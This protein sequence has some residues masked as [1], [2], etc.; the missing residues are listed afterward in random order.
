MENQSK[1]P[2]AEQQYEKALKASP[3]DLNALVGLARLHDRQGQ[4]VKAVQFYERAVKSHGKDALVYNDLGLYYARQKQL[5]KSIQYLAKAV[6]LQPDNARYRNNLATVLVESGR[7]GEAL[8]QLSRANS[9]AV[10]HY[11]VGF[12][13]HKRG[14][15]NEAVQHLQQ[16]IA[17]DPDLTPAREMLA[18]WSMGPDSGMVQQADPR[19]ADRP[20]YN[21]GN[22]YRT[23]V[24]SMPVSIEMPAADPEAPAGQYRISDEGNAN[25]AQAT[26]SDGPALRLPPLEE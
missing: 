14:Q 8:A 4:S 1:F 21:A 3:N 9:E 22:S 17:L 7:T 26:I 13:L 12:L 10:A 18:Q 5:D 24:P 16:A 15:Q 25:S 23:G 19:L 6:D 20:T 2:E 11:N